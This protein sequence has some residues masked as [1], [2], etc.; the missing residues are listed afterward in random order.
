MP[1]LPVLLLLCLQST[2][3][4]AGACASYIY[5]LG[6]AASEGNRSRE[7]I[8]AGGAPPRTA[9]NAHIF[10]FLC[11]GGYLDAPSFFSDL[12][13]QTPEP[14]PQTAE[15]P[16]TG[17]PA[18]AAAGAAAGAPA[19]AA[20]PSAA[21]DAEKTA[22]AVAE[23]ANA[24]IGAESG[25]IG[26]RSAAGDGAASAGTASA[27]AAPA[28]APNGN[29]AAGSSNSNGSCGGLFGSVLKGTSAFVSPFGSLVRHHT[30]FPVP[31]SAVFCCCFAFSRGH[32]Y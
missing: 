32:V 14:A 20:A 9:A 24:S 8:A 16:A 17:A 18:G 21:T 15:S 1:L 7:Q 31:L 6:A 29:T 23:A 3:N 22:A 30:K 11:L 26:A 25:G 19:P 28:A 10:V 12:L 13:L 2:E 5:L 27:E 4:R